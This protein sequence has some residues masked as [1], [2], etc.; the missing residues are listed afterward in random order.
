MPFTINVP[1]KLKNNTTISTGVFVDFDIHYRA[2]ELTVEVRYWESQ[3]FAESVKFDAGFK[4]HLEDKA[5]ETFGHSLTV[6][7]YNGDSGHIMAIHN[8]AREG[9]DQDDPLVGDTHIDG[10]DDTYGAANVILTSY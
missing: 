1:V 7:Q 5:I 10:L 8:R 4:L 2:R 9:Y 3:I 6:S